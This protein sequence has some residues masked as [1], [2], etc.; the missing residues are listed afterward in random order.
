LTCVELLLATVFSKQAILKI[1]APRLDRQSF[2][3]IMEGLKQLPPTIT[4]D[5]L[6]KAASSV[7]MSDELTRQIAMAGR[8]QKKNAAASRK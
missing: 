7:N 3:E 5:E 8:A 4:E 2:G 6:F 1:L